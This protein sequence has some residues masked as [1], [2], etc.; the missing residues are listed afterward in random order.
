VLL[1]GPAIDR[2]PLEK[3]AQAIPL[4]LTQPITFGAKVVQLSA[5]IGMLLPDQAVSL[6]GEATLRVADAAMYRAVAGKARIVVHEHHD[7]PAR[8]HG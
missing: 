3:I 7:S 2:A 6:S 8:M 4:T 1:T 5:S